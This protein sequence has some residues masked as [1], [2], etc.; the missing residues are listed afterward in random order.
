MPARQ[1]GAANWRA[2]RP[3][4]ASNCADRCVPAIRNLAVMS[5]ASLWFVRLRAGRSSMRL[6]WQPAG[7]SAPVAYGMPESM[8]DERVKL[9][10][11][12]L[13]WIDPDPLLARIALA[14]ETGDPSH[15]PAA[16]DPEMLRDTLQLGWVVPTA[17]ADMP[18]PEAARPAA[19]RLPLN[20]AAV[21]V[22]C[23]AAADAAVLWAWLEGAT[24]RAELGVLYRRLEK[25]RLRLEKAGAR[26]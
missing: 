14:R 1:R 3:V 23:C 26:H 24:L 15:L 2:A 9:P 19:Q 20:E 22:R 8:E 10:S 17:P 6:P 18:V 11:G 21:F 16:H 5:T 13:C 7:A 4:G 25:E 12:T